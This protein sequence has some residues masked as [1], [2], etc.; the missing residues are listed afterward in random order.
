MKPGPKVNSF[1][2]KSLLA[3]H[4]M[5][6]LGINPLEMLKEIYDEAREA[7]KKSSTPYQND[8]GNLI[9]PPGDAAMLA[10][11]VRAA[12]ELAGYKHPKLSAIAIQDL[13]ERE[14]DAKPMTTEEAMK[15]IQNDPF[16]KTKDRVV[17]AINATIDV[18][19]LAGGKK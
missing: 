5:D 3:H 2:K 14:K 6:R 16:N 12:T 4:E 13:N 11:A 19:V 8:Q 10:V 18:P 1:S 7:F 15:V 17:E 9:S